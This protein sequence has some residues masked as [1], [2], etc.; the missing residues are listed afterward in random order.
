M[1][2]VRSTFLLSFLAAPLVS[3]PQF[4]RAADFYKDK[5][6]TII[7]GMSAGGGYDAYARGLASHL[8]DHVPGNPT[9]VVQNMPGA[10]SFMAVRA[11]DATEP[12]DGTVMVSFDPGLITQSLVQPDK[13]NLDFRKFA[14]I[15]IV[16]PDFRVCYGFGPAKS[17]SLL[18]F[19]KP[20]LLSESYAASAI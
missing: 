10:G 16:T 14:W 8:A 13:V 2:R 5:T 4:A 1:F 19:A 18:K 3:A 15:G 6:L 20:S 7:V 9:I 17:R 12:K 11:L